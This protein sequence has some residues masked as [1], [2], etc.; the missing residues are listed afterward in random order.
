MNLIPVNV[1]G[2]G[3]LKTAAG[4]ELAIKP[5]DVPAAVRGRGA[6]LGLC[7]ED[8]VLNAPGMRVDVEMVET[9]GSEQLVHGR[10]GAADL[11]VRCTTRQLQ[12]ATIKPGDQMNVGPDG[13]HPLHWF[14]QDSGKRIQGT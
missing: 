3:T 14:D 4:V 1:Q 2:D 5:N 12:E 11:V 9:L 6:V 8:M 7:P 13:R 10:C